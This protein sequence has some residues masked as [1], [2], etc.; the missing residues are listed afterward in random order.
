LTKKATADNLWPMAEVPRPHR[1]SLSEKSYKVYELRCEILVASR[2]TS[3]LH[4]GNSQACTPYQ[5][6]CS[7][8]WMRTVC[9]PRSSREHRYA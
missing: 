5:S 1:T 4:N 6:K 9:W 7:L 3:G 8:E 2:G